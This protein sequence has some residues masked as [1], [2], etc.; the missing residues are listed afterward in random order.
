LN[1][2]IK[3]LIVIRHPVGGIRTY[4]KYTYRYLDPARYHL[5]ILTVK[6]REGV[7]INK[8][9]EQFNVDYITV[10]GKFIL[11]LIVVKVTKLLQSN[12]FDL[13]HSQ[14]YTA[15]VLSVLGNLLSR[16]PHIITSHD[17]F[18]P[19]QFSG[20]WGCLKRRLLSFFLGQA[21]V[22][23][24]VSEDAQQNLVEFLPS[25]GKKKEN[26]IVILNGIAVSQLEGN[27]NDTSVLSVR[28]QFDLEDGSFLFGFL[29][30]FMPQ[31][32][33]EYLIEAVDKISRE[34]DIPQNFYILAANEGAFIRE[35]KGLVEA[36]DLS[37]YFK[38]IGFVP[39]VGKILKELDALVIPSLW[40]ACPLQPMEAFLLGCPVIA[41]NCIGLRE[42]IRDSPA[43]VV[44]SRDSASLAAAMREFMDNPEPFKHRA[45]D[46]IAEA[47]L[48]F[49][50]R[51]T[52]K[53]LGA[54][55]EKV[56]TSPKT[57]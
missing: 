52:A 27:E 7:L 51:K 54:L 50:S 39:K 28:E 2:K 55:F 22:I 34:T 16:T 23:Q 12:H 49:D 48:R 29:G 33:F 17:V 32:G 41:S 10:E 19:D 43:R 36:K 46:F 14:G 44:Q 40:E 45:T 35:Y 3:V 4:L 56:I 53:Q 5:T 26:L 8:D 6:D 47:R 38:F 13:I 24:S 31:K 1:D 15:G 25:L 42:V 30:R 20:F 9:L 37:R 21:D 11:P 18:R 57:G